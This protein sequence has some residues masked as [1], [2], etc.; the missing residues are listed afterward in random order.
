[1]K[2][3]AFGLSR[4][5]WGRLE[6]IDAEGRRFAG[7][8]P[9]RAFPLSD[10][11]R[12]VSLCDD[13]GREVAWIDDLTSLPPNIR[14]LLEEELA[15]REFVPILRKILRISSDSAPSDWDV[16]TDRGDTRFTLES[17]EQIRRIGPHRLLIADAAGLR[18]QIPDTRA[19]DAASRGW[20]ERYL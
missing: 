2:D 11:D 9:V 4:D 19:M 7:V 5:P 8:E 6:L 16:E 20:L 10:P 18:Y 13:S 17:D 14:T 1:V 3:F 15:S 12:G